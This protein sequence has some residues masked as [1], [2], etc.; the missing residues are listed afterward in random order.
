MNDQINSLYTEL[1]NLK[2]ELIHAGSKTRDLD[3]ANSQLKATNDK[4]ESTL[5]EKLEV[6]KM[7]DE[8]HV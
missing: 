8:R 6:I 4:L 2:T 5:N 7:Q 1:E 3:R